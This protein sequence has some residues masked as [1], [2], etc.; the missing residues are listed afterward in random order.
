MKFPK[1]VPVFVANG[2]DI[3]PQFCTPAAIA[4]M[5]FFFKFCMQGTYNNR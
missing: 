5:H 4:G 3:L 2:W 1:E